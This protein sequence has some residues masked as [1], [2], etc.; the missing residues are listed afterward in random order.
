MKI[1]DKIQKGVI[2]G[3]G[4]I[5]V[6]GSSGGVTAGPTGLAIDEGGS[7]DFFSLNDGSG[8]S[9]SSGGGNDTPDYA[10][11]QEQEQK[12]MQ[13]QIDAIKNDPSY[14]GLEALIGG[15]NPKTGEYTGAV[16]DFMGAEFDQYSADQASGYRSNVENLLGI[17]G[18]VGA[19]GQQFQDIGM[20]GADPRFAAF[21]DAQMAQL[22]SQEA[23]AQQ[24][25]STFF[26]RR[27]L[28]GSSAALNQAGKTQ[29]GFDQRRTALEAG[30]GMQ[31]MGRQDQALMQA[32]GLFGQQAGIQSEG[33]QLGFNIDTGIINAANQAQLLG[34]ESKA[35]GI[36]TASLPTQ[37]DI[38]ALAAAN[39][40]RQPT[41]QSSGL[42]RATDRVGGW[43]DTGL[44]YIG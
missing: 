22:G 14:A 36:E 43:L 11:L 15:Y 10:A 20:G 25:E 29:A 31:Q 30:L 44:S 34:L 37:L 7:A 35:A 42:G 23:A 19:I 24:R 41:P 8:G 21:R 16:G 1:L 40:G 33:T 13:Q 18:Q 32:A 28:G 39:A 2:N 26:G 27:G 38:A 12:F 4:G 17:G 5:R 3:I 9:G 6:G